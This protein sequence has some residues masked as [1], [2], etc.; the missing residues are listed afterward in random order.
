MKALL[1]M[2]SS[3]LSDLCAYYLRPLGF[4]IIRYRDPLKAM[5]N[6]DEVN[7]DAIV[8]SAA[9]FPRHW[10]PFVQLLRASRG[11]DDAVF[12]L[13]KGDRFALEEA[14]KAVFLGVNGVV[15]QNLRDSVELEHFQQ[16]LRRY[17]SIS[18]KR[19]CERF[20]PGAEDRIELVFAHPETFTIISGKIESISA[21]GVAFKPFYS[22]TGLG[23]TPG[24][25]INDISLR[26]GEKILSLSARVIRYSSVLVL[27]FTEE[28]EA[29]RREIDT[30]LLSYSER[31]VDA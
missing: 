10:K 19:S 14:S 6:L 21:G 2:E 8:M 22:E 16:V 28:S 9:E 31:L 24:D 25:L 27:E 20:V 4:E 23:F 5:D 15:R 13:L 29:E 12:I 30:F 11:K 26:L 17:L 7:P 18:D 3:K 1:V